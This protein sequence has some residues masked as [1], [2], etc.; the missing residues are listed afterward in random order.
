M[1]RDNGKT[2]KQRSLRTP[3][4]FVLIAFNTLPL[5]ESGSQARR[6]FLLLWIGIASEFAFQN[7]FREIGKLLE[8][9]KALSG[10]ES[11]TLPEGE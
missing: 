1:L 10:P 2:H 7:N 9:V 5:G 4:V 3:S 6:G 8:H 11:P